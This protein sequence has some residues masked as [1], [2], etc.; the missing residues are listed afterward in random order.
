M[1]EFLPSS[2]QR[3]GRHSWL[4]TLTAVVGLVLVLAIVK[5][6]GDGAPPAQPSSGAR[7]TART[8]N[9]PPTARA[10][11]T[12]YEPRLFGYREPDP[13][14]ELW[15]AG[16]VFEFGLAGPVPVH[17]AA[18][19][20]AASAPPRLVPSPAPTE[21]AG[22]PSVA[23]LDLGPADH[24]IAIGL[25]TPADVRVTD[26]GLWILRGDAC[27]AEPLPYVRLPT[28]W[29]SDHF[30]VIAAED[31]DQPGQPGPWPVAEY[32]LDLVLL[33]DEVVSIAFRVT[34]PVG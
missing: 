18:P 10:P 24:L 25:N 29:E 8:T 34:E 28:L 20:G 2:V 9:L 4:S 5:P 7:A 21:S 33:S 14:W 30:F 19:T 3:P 27:C 32:R 26:I 6:W 23:V 15:P 22:P 17:S 31:P 16:F 11:R 13:G 1:A 12:E